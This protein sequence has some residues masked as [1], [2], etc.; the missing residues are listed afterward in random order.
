MTTTSRAFCIFVTTCAVVLC[1]TIL[2][3]FCAMAFS[4]Q[5]GDS[6]EWLYLVIAALLS[7]LSVA[8][9]G[10]ILYETARLVPPIPSGGRIQMDNSSPSE[11]TAPAYPPSPALAANRPVDWSRP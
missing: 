5:S 7:A 3:L 1:I 11:A 8:L 9:V 6:L 2:M 4:R 10:A